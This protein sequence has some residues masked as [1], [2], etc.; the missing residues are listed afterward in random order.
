[1]GRRSQLGRHRTLLVQPR[2]DSRALRRAP[3]AHAL[4]YGGDEEGRLVGAAE[5]QPEEVGRHR[6]RQ[7]DPQVQPQEACGWRLSMRTTR[8][9]LDEATYRPG[10]SDKAAGRHGGRTTTTESCVS[11]SD[12]L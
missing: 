7:G 12:T 8:Q 9:H 4:R 2:L 6:V 11:D 5:D 1:M 3:R 10:N